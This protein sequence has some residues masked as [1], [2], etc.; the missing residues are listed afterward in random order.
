MRLP[1][2]E[3]RARREAESEEKKIQT[4]R[5]AGRKP[6]PKQP[7]GMYDLQKRRQ[8]EGRGQNIILE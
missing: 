8:K 3:Q 6:T 5:R 7:R 2:K 1:R 4:G